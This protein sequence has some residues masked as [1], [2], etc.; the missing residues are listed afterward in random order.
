MIEGILPY[1][2][3]TGRLP[4]DV[5]IEEQNLD[6]VKEVFIKALNRITDSFF[7]ERARLRGDYLNMGEILH[8]AQ[9]GDED[10]QFLLKLYD[11]I[12]KKEDALEQQISQMKIS[13]LQGLDV[14]VLA[15]KAYIQVEN[16][17]T[18]KATEGK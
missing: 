9:Q 1:V 5:Q 3:E 15:Y 8:D 10:A 2:T 7:Y 12:W 18:S 17:I 6:E 14:R 13:E 11:G 16:E 4:G